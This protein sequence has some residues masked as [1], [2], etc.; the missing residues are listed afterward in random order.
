MNGCCSGVGHVGHA[1]WPRLPSSHILVSREPRADPAP[2]GGLTSRQRTG[3]CSR[4]PLREAGEIWLV[5]RAA[6]TKL[7]ICPGDLSVWGIE[8]RGWQ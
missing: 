4:P 1:G 6:K 2:K 5:D 8:R 3:A 7:S